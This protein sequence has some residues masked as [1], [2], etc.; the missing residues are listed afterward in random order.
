MDKIIIENLSLKYSDGV[1]SLH[2]I[3][4]RVPENKITTLF[5]PAGGGK[6]TLLRVLNRLN[7]LADVEEVSGNV[8]VNGINV[9]DPDI[10]VIALRRKIG[11]VFS[12]PI[13]LPF[14]IYQNISY[15]LELA[16]IKDKKHIDHAV[17]TALRQ[18]VLWEEVDDRLHSPASKLSGGQKQ[19]L[20]IARSLALKPDILL[21]DEPTSA[22]DPVSTSKIE[23]FLRKAKEYITIVLVPHN[24]QQ[25]ARMADFAGFFLQ[26]KL[27]EFNEGGEMFINPK[28]KQT[29]DYIRGK[30]G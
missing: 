8:V 19:R 4:L 9:L 3:S 16:G 14:T 5:G 20:C 27:I 29:E 6:S 2:D 1:E 13:P 30:F 11:M 24:T 7:D 17:E 28:E 23:D 10:D 26:G 18:V 12:R 22:L 15:G 21:L 25:A